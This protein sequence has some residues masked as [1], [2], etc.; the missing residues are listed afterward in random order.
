LAIQAKGPAGE[1]KS[2]LSGPPSETRRDCPVQKLCLLPGAGSHPGGSL[3]KGRRS[4]STPETESSAKGNGEC[5]ANGADL[6]ARV[7]PGERANNSPSPGMSN[8]PPL[9]L[10]AGSGGGFFKQKF[11]RT[12]LSQAIRIILT[13]GVTQTPCRGV[14]PRK[15]SVLWPWI[16]TTSLQKKRT[17]VHRLPAGRKMACLWRPHVPG[18]ALTGAN[19]GHS[20]R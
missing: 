20:S 14:N 10:R 8:E 13:K 17:C 12:T 1:G 19:S 5:C 16:N 3:R 15:R 9:S 7:K 6:V 4:L 11:P 2:Y 18:H